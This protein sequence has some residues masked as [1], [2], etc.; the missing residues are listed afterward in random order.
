MLKVTEQEMLN[1]LMAEAGKAG[2][3]AYHTYD[4]RR[5]KA[6]FPDVVLMKPPRMILIELKGPRGHASS[7]QKMVMQLAR[8]CTHIHAGFV[9]PAGLSDLL[10]G[11]WK[12]DEFWPIKTCNVA[13]C[14]ETR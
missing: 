7:D 4:S 12:P 8:E 5:S 1:Q 13:D 14:E 11:L 10:A 9:W 3:Y 2:W 6:G